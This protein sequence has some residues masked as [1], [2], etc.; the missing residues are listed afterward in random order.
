MINTKDDTKGLGAVPKGR[1]ALWISLCLVVVILA[2][3]AQVV[4]HPFLDL[5]DP[6]YVTENP[7][8]NNGFTLK[9]VLWAFTTIH[10]A[11]WHPITWLSHMLD[12]QMYGRD[13]GGHHLTNVFFHILNTLLLLTVLHHMTGRLWPSSFVAALFALHPLHVESV[14][15]VAERKDVLSTFFWMLTL[16][17]YAIYA[18][19]PGARRYLAVLLF[20][21]LG[22]MAKP[23]VV[24]L[25]FVLLLLDFWPLGRMDPH[26]GGAAGTVNA[27]VLFLEKIP[28]MF[29]SALSCVITF[30]SQQSS[31]AVSTL[32][33]VPLTIRIVN[34]LVSYAAYIGKM[35]WPTDLA[36]LYI[37]PDAFPL[38]QVSIACLVVGSLSVLSLVTVR[39]QPYFLVGWLW[40]LG[41]LVPVIGLVQVGLQTMACRYTYIPLIGLF[42]MVAFGYARLLSGSKKFRIVG[43]VLPVLVVV[44]CSTLTW[45][46][47]QPWKSSVALFSHALDVTT[48]NY[49]AH[50][51]LGYALAEQGQM[52]E[53]ISQYDAA[54]RLNPDFDE[55]R[56]KF[57][58]Q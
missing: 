36:V 8:V 27:K 19:K 7:H 17:T 56:I 42:I 23:M 29:F 47:L 52:E 43:A 40:Y 53:A 12:I 1:R 18:A 25:P 58:P 4:H 13:P 37:Y 2:V 9:N 35:F 16:W 3:Y 45:R 41:T 54:L 20:F 26:G 55:V 46:Q 5:D 50:A 57:G 38:W 22:L 14:A 33:A 15:W 39:S 31:G 24:T 49:A 10:S 48:D 21:I 11:N 30:Y 44:A 34:A 6:A 28:L 51:N 32:Q